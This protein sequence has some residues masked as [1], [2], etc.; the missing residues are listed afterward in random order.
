MRP[1]RLFRT[2]AFRL[3]GWFAVL[4]LVCIAVLFATIDWYAIGTLRAELRGTVSARLGAILA[5]QRGTDCTGLARSVTEAIAE[6]P[7]AYA[8]L[9]DAAGHRLAGNLP[10][11]VERTGWVTLSVPGSR[12][13]GGEP[14]PVLARGVHL[15][16]GGY[17]LVGQDAFALKE[18]NELV[19]R[20]FALGGALT[21]ALALAGGFLVSRSV[22][23]RIAR[24]GQAG[25]S[26]MR[27]DLSRRL[28]TRG[29]GDELDQLVAGFNALLDRIG[30]LVEA[31]RQVTN[32]IAHDLRTPLTRLRNR[33]GEVRR[34]PRGPAEYEA[35]IDRSIADSDAILD[36]FAALLRIAQI[37]AIT[38]ETQLAPVA[39]P[40]LVAT[41][42]ELYQPLAEERE[43]TLT[44]EAEDFCLRGDRELLIQMLGNLVENACRHT[45][46]GARIGVG[47]QRRG[48]T[49][50]LWVQDNGP[51]IPAAERE[52]VFR[53]FYRLDASRTAPGSGLGLSLVA[54]IAARHRGRVRL[55]DAAPGVRAEVML[56]LG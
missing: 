17:L 13:D 15:R 18:L 46:P 5:D 49:A 47:A 16:G 28:P 11:Q 23:R 54:A 2:T 53:R 21:L 29:T 4:L 22:L 27:G 50:L 55:L 48:G 12:A 10:A 9:L 1:A 41:V 51:G 7:G 35:A 24:I 43:Q 14:H 37:E 25:Q 26:I 39:A 40:I 52:R 19:V 20:A 32:D 44:G 6:T 34:R 38:D 33:L 36:T 42:V 30:A 8:L 31:M 3:T 45:G 56:P